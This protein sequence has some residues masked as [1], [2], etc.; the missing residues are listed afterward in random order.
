MNM[1]AE[2]YPF[3]AVATRVI[4]DLIPSDLVDRLTPAQLAKIPLAIA[5]AADG[6]SFETVLSTHLRPMTVLGWKLYPE[7]DDDEKIVIYDLD[8]GLIFQTTAVGLQGLTPAQFGAMYR[9][10][11]LSRSDRLSR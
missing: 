2:R 7:D 3:S 9:L 1:V 6:V 5:L 11:R 8:T 10:D 4:N